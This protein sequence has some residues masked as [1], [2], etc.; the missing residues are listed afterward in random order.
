MQPPRLAFLPLREQGAE[1]K[2]HRTGHPGDAGPPR[3]EAGQEPVRPRLCRHQGFAVLIQPLTEGR[4]CPRCGHGLDGRSG[5]LRRRHQLRHPQGDAF[6]GLSHSGEKRPS[7]HR[8]PEAEG[9]DAPGRAPTAKEGLQA[10]RHR[11]HG[12]VPHRERRGEHPRLLAQ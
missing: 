7:L 10:L 9:G 3:G 6:R 2:P 5:L 1:D 4:P 12:E 11:R 8:R